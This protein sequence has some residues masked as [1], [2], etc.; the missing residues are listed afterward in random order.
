MKK[1]DIPPIRH[2]L[3]DGTNLEDITDYHVPR[4]CPVY[5]VL[6]R[7]DLIAEVEK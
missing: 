5:D 6:E 7:L 4:S 3:L 2:I 1:K